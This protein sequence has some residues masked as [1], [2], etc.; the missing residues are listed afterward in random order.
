MRRGGTTIEMCGTVPRGVG[1]SNGRCRATVTGVDGRKLEFKFVLRDDRDGGRVAGTAAPFHAETTGRESTKAGSGRVERRIARGRDGRRES[2]NLI[3]QGREPHETWAVGYGRQAVRRF[4]AS[5]AG[6]SP[7]R[8][9]HNLVRDT[10]GA[11]H[12]RARRRASDVPVGVVVS[13]ATSFPAVRLASLH[14]LPAAI[15]PPTPQAIAATSLA[16]DHPSH[17]PDVGRPRS[18]RTRNG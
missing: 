11:S 7:T 1:R 14:R 8:E 12:R 3:H 15:T 5:P 6:V 9:R 10:D 2:R 18:R 16:F 13:R 4:E 17:V